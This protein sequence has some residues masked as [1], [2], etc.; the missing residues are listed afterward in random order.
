[1]YPKK[2]GKGLFITKIA[3]LSGTWQLTVLTWERF[4]SFANKKIV[5]LGM[6]LNY[7]IHV[8][9]LSLFSLSSLLLLIRRCTN[10]LAFCNFI[11][12]GNSIACQSKTSINLYKYITHYA[13]TL[14]HWVLQKEMQL[15]MKEKKALGGILCIIWSER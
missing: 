4:V 12:Y 1:M 7:N 6:S 15:K 14:F 13:S 10:G 11:Y 9:F 8:E 2:K 5:I 3:K